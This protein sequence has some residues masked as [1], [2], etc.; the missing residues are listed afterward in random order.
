MR[1]S[2]NILL[3]FLVLS[4]SMLTAVTAFADDVSDTAAKTRV[5]RITLVRGDVR[6]QRVD[7][8]DLETAAVNVP[9]VEGDKLT[10]GVDSRLEIQ[11]DAYNF[12][13]VNSNSKVSI[14]TL[15]PEG[16]A[17]ALSDG[18]ADVRLSRFDPKKEYFEVDAP[19]S[20]FA[21]E[22]K[23]LYRIDAVRGAGGNEEV[24]I[25][26]RDGGRAR[27][28]SDTSGFTLRDGRS[29]RLFVDGPN[30]GDW[31][32]ATASALDDWDNWNE[33]REYDLAQRL[34]YERRDVYYNSS[35]WGAEEL[36]SYGGWIYSSTYG[37]VWRPSSI[38]LSSYYGWA[39]YRF[40][41]WSWIRPWGWTWIC[42]EPWGWA[43]YH[44]GSWVFWG[45][46]WAWSPYGYWGGSSYLWQ[47]HYCNFYYSPTYYGQQI[48]WYPAPPRKRPDVV[49]GNPPNPGPVTPPA[50]TKGDQAFSDI[51]IKITGPLA[52]A[53]ANAVSTT[54]VT[55]F[56]STK[57]PI[58]AAPF[59]LAQMA[60]K[61]D[62]VPTTTLPV[63]PVKFD[64]NAG[65]TTKSSSA[66]SVRNPDREGGIKAAAPDR[67]TGAAV[68]KPGVALDDQLQRTRLRNGR[69]P[70]GTPTLE[71]RNPTPDTGAVKR[72][73]VD[74]SGSN[75][76]IRVGPGPTKGAEAP[77]GGSQPIR[78]PRPPMQ[79][80]PEPVK[81]S[82]PVRQQPEPEPAPPVKYEPPTR[83]EP[84]PR[85][86]PP[87]RYEPPPRYDPP[88]PK[89]DPPPSKPSE[90]VNSGRGKGD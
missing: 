40:G 64:T 87:P 66:V 23:G 83:Y 43:T 86:D 58:K 31:E 9:L 5:A 47:P 32:L 56:G 41:H 53:Y 11:I 12:I 88:P 67:Q 4:I 62:P 90:S 54:P 13:R 65:P 69:E 74:G 3:S 63:S 79:S 21:A 89:A 71:I 36:D 76:P 75:E 20:T 70:I 46:S 80:D 45:G 82:P 38:A 44:Y 22:K 37:Y 84:P 77:T 18:T 17:I 19:K 16:V 52:G 2:K 60:I 85:N 6:L 25:T 59:A 24:R 33:Q 78:T 35:I 1:H 48:C 50:P 55:S 81:A 57:P 42:D 7:S 72:S 68:R 61:S 39:P 30:G 34:R 29:A 10:T 51:K 27:V 8:Q 14:I 28:Y 15:R 73:T 26:V 49:T